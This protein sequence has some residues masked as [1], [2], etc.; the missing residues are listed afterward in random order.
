MNI[1]ELFVKANAKLIKRSLINRI[2][3]FICKPEKPMSWEEFL[4]EIKELG[5]NELVRRTI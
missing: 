5:D 2:F 4:A 3:P 1:E